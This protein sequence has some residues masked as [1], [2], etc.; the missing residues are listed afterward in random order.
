MEPQHTFRSALRGAGGHCD[1]KGRVAPE[2]LARAWPSPVWDVELFAVEVLFGTRL[3]F[4]F[5]EYCKGQGDT[6]D[7]PSLGSLW[8]GRHE[9]S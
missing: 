4:Y 1:T 7:Q 2:K 6:K 5:F 9:N 8:E 3:Q